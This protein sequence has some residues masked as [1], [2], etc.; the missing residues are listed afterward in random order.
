MFPNSLSRC[1]AAFDRYERQL[2]SATTRSAGEIYHEAEFE[3]HFQRMGKLTFWKS[4]N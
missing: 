3:S 4:S 2:K 1:E